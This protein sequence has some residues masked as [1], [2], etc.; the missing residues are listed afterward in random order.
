MI[1]YQEQEHVRDFD[2]EDVDNIIL[3]EPKEHTYPSGIV[4]SR[5]EVPER[6]GI[7]KSKSGPLEF[8][9]QPLSDLMYQYFFFAMKR[10]GIIVDGSHQYVIENKPDANKQRM[11]GK[12]EESCMVET[13]TIPR[14]KR[15]RL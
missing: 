3:L 9:V 6:F 1:A 12:V 13:T 8:S 11:I 15:K 10:L 5:R 7:R 2:L 4:Q 14:I